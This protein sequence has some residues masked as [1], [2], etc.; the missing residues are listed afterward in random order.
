MLSLEVQVS[1]VGVVVGENPV[2]VMGVIRTAVRGQRRHVVTAS[3]LTALHQACEALVPVLIGVIIDDAVAAEGYGRLVLW[4]VVLGVTFAVLSY[5]FRFGARRAERAVEQAA[6]ELRLLLAARVLDPR[7]GAEKGRLSGELTS[8]ATGDAMR[9]GALNRALPYGVATVVAVVVTAVA[10]LWISVP[11]GL[12]VLLGTPP[13]LWVANLFGRPLERRSEAERERA[14]DAS[15]VAA[16]LVSGLRVLKG[17]GAEPAA[18]ARYRTTSQDALAATVKAAGAKAW[19]DGGMLALNGIFLAVVALIG[20]RLAASG[21][22]S[23]GGLIAAVG[24]AQFL[25]GPLT[26]FVWVSSEVAQARGSAARLAT[27]LSAPPAVAPGTGTLTEPV[28]GDVR[29]RAVSHAGLNGLDLHVPA[30]Q[31]LGVVAADPAEANALLACLSRAVDPA[32]GSVELDGVAL[33]E[34]TIDHVRAVMLVAAHDADLFEG[35]LISNVSTED[36]RVLAAAGADE[37]AHAL[38]DGIDTELTERARSLSGG[39][40]QRV[41]LARALAVDAPVLALHDPTTA[42][43]AVTEARIAAGIKE[44]R[45][46]RTTILVTTSPALLAVADRVVVLAGGVITADGDHHELAAADADYRAVVLA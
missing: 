32:D 7:G 16:D 26:S 42:V 45:R 18:I 5:S 44:L 24:L 23:I 8:L 40:R 22:M 37:V 31:L 4:L 29:L 1:G 21:D 6:H 17:L 20:G 19:H 41:A 39:Q 15:G 33:P 13:L 30:G 25:I 10:L 43:D 9:V 36:E 38:P 11:L 27:L 34:L 35:T 46:G 12:F 14:A 2:G 28:R 3:V